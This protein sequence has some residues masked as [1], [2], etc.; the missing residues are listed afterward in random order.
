MADKGKFSAAWYLLQGN[1]LIMN[2]LKCLNATN[3]AEKHHLLL[4]LII[5]S[6]RTWHRL[7]KKLI[8]KIEKYKW[9]GT[10]NYLTKKSLYSQVLLGRMKNGVV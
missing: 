6:G 9:Y 7:R 3:C 4:K 8:D 10:E 1:I 2:Q 5:A